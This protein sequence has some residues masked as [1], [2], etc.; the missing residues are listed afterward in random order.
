[1]KTW[2][3]RLAIGVGS[4]VGLVVLLLGGVYGMSASAVGTGHPAEA[5]PFDASIGDALEGAR[6]GNMYGC[7]HCHT[8]DLGGQVM[9]DGMP[10]IRIAASN[11]TGGAAGGGFT[12]EEFE[13]AMRHGI[14]RDGRKLF[15][16]PSA[17][18]TYLS[19][20]DIADLLV[21]I[22]SLPVV[23]RELP[24]RTFGPVGRTMV[25]LGKVP[26]QS[27]LIDADPDAEHLERP[28]PDNPKQLGY[29]YTRLCTGCHGL[30]LAGAPPL[31]PGAPAGPNLTP[32]GNLASWSLDDF[33]NVFAT[34]RTPDGR[35]LDPDIMPWQAIGNAQPHEVEAIWTYLQSLPAKEGPVAK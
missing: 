23:E 6:L 2:Q 34:G 4:L 35:Q 11:I 3:R 29:Y 31:E 20:Q 30:D 27:D 33:R 21:W 8:P 1:M 25:A 18:Y 13:Q 7:T 9:I 12:D 17:E 14:G 10:F 15:I 32:A 28:S 26:F 16:M 19:D 22:R 24:A 5:H